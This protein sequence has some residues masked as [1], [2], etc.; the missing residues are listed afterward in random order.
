MFLISCTTLL[1]PYLLERLVVHEAGRILGYV[2]LPLLDVLAELPDMARLSAR[3][4]LSIC[5]STVA[6]K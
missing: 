3:A 5:W 2:K 4:L 1:L 6:T